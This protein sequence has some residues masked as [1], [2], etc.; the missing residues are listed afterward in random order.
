MR[1]PL[2]P[3]AR[4]GQA[5]STIPLGGY[6]ED[7]TE[8]WYLQISWLG[9]MVSVEIGSVARSDRMIERWKREEAS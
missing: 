1:R 3:R 5:S 4:W 2:L 6:D 8:G 7:G 9:W